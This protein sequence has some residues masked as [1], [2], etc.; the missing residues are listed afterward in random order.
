M[1]C[2]IDTVSHLKGSLCCQLLLFFIWL[3]SFSRCCG[4]GYEKYH[5][6]VIPHYPDPDEPFPPMYPTFPTRYEPVLTGKCPVKFSAIS[7]IMDK[8][9]SDCSQP[10]AALVGNVICCPQLS[11]L[12]RIFQGLY[13]L[14]SAKLVLQNSVASDC[15]TD[16]ISILASRGANS[17]IPTLCS[18]KSSNLTG[19]SCP[20]QDVYTF[21]KTVNTSRLLEACTTVDPLKECCRPIC[22]PA[23]M[24]AALQI[25]GKQLT[26]DENKNLVGEP[27]HIDTLSDCKGVV[28]A[29]LSRKLSPDVVNT[30]FR[31]LSACKVNKVCPL[32]FKQPLEGGVM[33]NI[34]DL[35]DVDL[36]DF[37]IQ[38]YGQQSKKVISVIAVVHFHHG[39]SSSSISSVSLCGPEMSLP[40]YQ[41]QRLLKTLVCCRCGGELKFLVPIIS[42][43]VFG[44]LLY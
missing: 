44:T 22:Q 34:Y 19:G 16:I 32:D 7:S 4:I 28:Y 12:I 10:L 14:N 29:Y 18:V 39:P 21:E 38:A 17:T 33:T 37:S 35:C 42:F 43:L 30:A 31:I 13:S 23:I 25:S 41:H 27:N 24:D 36:K 26:L 20:V 11:S 8:T 40:A 1:Y 3:S 5:P 2:E 6:A 9:A 15:F